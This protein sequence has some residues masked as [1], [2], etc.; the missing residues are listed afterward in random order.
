V[1]AETPYA[2]ANLDPLPAELL[3]RLDPWFEP[4]VAGAND[5][6]QEA[7]AEQSPDVARQMRDMFGN[8]LSADTLRRIGIEPNIQFVA[9]GIGFA[10]VVRVRL[11]DADLL[12]QNLEMLFAASPSSP[13][14]AVFH[15]QQYWYDLGSD[16]NLFVFAIVKSDAVFAM[17][18]PGQVQREILPLAFGQ[19]P[20]AASMASTGRMIRLLEDHSL[21]RHYVGFIDSEVV[22]CTVLGQ[23]RGL[24]KQVAEAMGAALRVSPECV[25]DATRVARAFP[26]VVVG[27]DELSAR[28]ITASWVIEM[29]PAVAG[30]V[31]EVAAPIPGLPPDHKRDG[32]MR[33]G[34]GVDLRA[35]DRLL[36]R[37]ASQIR[38]APFACDEFSWITEG[39]A[40]VGAAS[41]LVPPALKAI[42][43]VGIV[44]FDAKEE[45]AK[46]PATLDAVTVLGVDDPRE[47]LEAVAGLT[48]EIQIDELDRP[49]KPVDYAKVFSGSPSD[50]PLVMSSQVAYGAHAIGW[51]IGKEGKRALLGALDRERPADGALAVGSIDI[52]KALAVAPGTARKGLEDITE[53]HAREA[54]EALLGMLGTLAFRIKLTGRGADVEVDLAVPKPGPKPVPKPRT[55]RP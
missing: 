14:S 1:P 55:R 47:A 46:A 30:A 41:V 32:V 53:P 26:K 54:A 37:F 29:S 27:F 10:P 28:R 22:V 33:G 42:R 8:E 44:V 11:A 7:L 4:L 45:T 12:R 23:A 40:E 49:R 20:P 16:G 19:R 31:S 48:S 3:R 5:G 52:R 17:L 9:Y 25:A 38:E 35:V 39:A 43:G 21:T 18:P 51:G 36:G 2:Y 24:D 13:R 34:I 6:Y 15:G 50:D